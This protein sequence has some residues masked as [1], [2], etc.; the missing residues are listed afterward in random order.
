M[1]W[2]ARR[3]IE[4]EAV[5]QCGLELSGAIW[6]EQKRGARWLSHLQVT[7]DG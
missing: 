7:Q 5:E 6:G 2:G 3:Q 4:D 1:D